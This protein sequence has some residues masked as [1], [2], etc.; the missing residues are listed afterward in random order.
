MPTWKSS[1]WRLFSRRSPCDGWHP[2]AGVASSNAA[3]MGTAPVAPAASA[4]MPMERAVAP[5]RPSGY[6]SRLCDSLALEINDSEQLLLLQ[7]HAFQQEEEAEE[8][9]EQWQVETET[10]DLPDVCGNWYHWYRNLGGDQK[11]K[12]DE[13]IEASWAAREEEKNSPRPGFGTAPCSEAAP[14]LFNSVITE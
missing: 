9:D 10:K 13:V 11:D 3:A 7:L 4:S 6:L 14:C 1:A 2:A 5:I 12:K 8:A